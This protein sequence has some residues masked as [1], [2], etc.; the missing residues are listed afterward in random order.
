MVEER[1]IVA[2]KPILK[3]K[4]KK[5]SLRLRGEKL[6]GERRIVCKG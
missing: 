3:V 1:A 5:M 2:T 4:E 6:K